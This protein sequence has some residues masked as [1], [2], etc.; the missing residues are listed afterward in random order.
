MTQIE[1]TARVTS[2]AQLQW[3]NDNNIEYKHRHVVTNRKT[4]Q[5]LDWGRVTFKYPEDLAM[6]NL[7]WN[8]DEKT[9]Q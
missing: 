2:Y 1:Y 8:T 7:R 4:G 6:Y 5:V 9:S 3:L